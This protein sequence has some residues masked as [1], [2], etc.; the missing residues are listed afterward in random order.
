MKYVVHITETLQKILIV[1]ADSLHEAEDK[2]HELYNN[3]QLILDYRDCNGYDVECVREAD[4]WDIEHID[5][6]EE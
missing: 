4:Q 2:I 5:E 3:E 6:L 1:E